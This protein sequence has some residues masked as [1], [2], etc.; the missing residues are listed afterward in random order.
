ME[1]EVSYGKEA[2]NYE[3]RAV[4][5]DHQ[6]HEKNNLVAG[7]YINQ[8]DIDDFRKVAVVGRK[9]STDL[10]K[11]ENP[12]G[13]YLRINGVLFEVVGLYADDGGDDEEDN[14]YLPINVGQATL[15]QQ[16][17]DLTE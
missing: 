15:S 9:I 13:K 16:P 1:C 8:Y 3:V 7:R 12:I 10:F 6:Y 11:G 14:V 2:G 5:P 17:H 4:H